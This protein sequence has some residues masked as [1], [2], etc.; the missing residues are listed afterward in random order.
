ME[1]IDGEG[2]RKNGCERYVAVLGRVEMNLTE[3]RSRRTEKQNAQGTGRPEG[4]STT[5]CVITLELVDSKAC[6]AN[7][8]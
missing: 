8:S 2:Q 3:K 5:H 1:A 6:K 4:P 7:D